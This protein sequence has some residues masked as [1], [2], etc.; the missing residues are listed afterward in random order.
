MLFILSL[1]LI[2]L[3]LAGTILMETAALQIVSAMVCV[4]GVILLIVYYQH[5]YNIQRTMNKTLKE[6]SKHLENEYNTMKSQKDA[7]IEQLHQK[8]EKLQSSIPAMPSEL[9]IEQRLE[10]LRSFFLEDEKNRSDYRR[11]F[12]ELSHAGKNQA[13][14]EKIKLNFTNPLMEKL[15]QV[16]QPIGENDKRELVGQLLQLAL[17]AIDFTEEFR[18]MRNGDDSLALS[19]AIGSMK[20]EDAALKASKAN[21]NVYETEKAHRVLS[22]LVSSLQLSGDNLIVHDTLLQPIQP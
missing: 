13:M 20:Q 7:N 4:I 3:G 18:T 22:E 17:I 9:P 1:I 11:L 14:L 6:Q 2:A 10:I 19:V 16:S 21:S 5:M 12:L 8:L 15:S